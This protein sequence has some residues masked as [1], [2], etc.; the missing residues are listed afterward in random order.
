MAYDTAMK[1]RSDGEEKAIIGRM[2]KRLQ[3]W[4]QQRRLFNN[5]R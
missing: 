5:F 3:A 1:R 2:A 4:L